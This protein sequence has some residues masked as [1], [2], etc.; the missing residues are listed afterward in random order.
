MN[1]EVTEYINKQKSPQKEICKRLRKII[2]KTYPDINEQFKMGVPWYG[3]YYLVALKDKVNMG[4]SIKGLSKKEQDLF[5][6]TGKTMKH[7]KIYSLKDIDE[8]KIVRLLKISKKS[9][10]SSCCK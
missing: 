5:E 4:F 9:E 7:I 1:K 10:C 8:K 6:G 2:L 3:K